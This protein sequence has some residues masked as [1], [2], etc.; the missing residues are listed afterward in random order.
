[1]EVRA[2]DLVSM[3]RRASGLT[4]ASE[5]SALVAL[6]GFAGGG[7]HFFAPRARVRPHSATRSAARRTGFGIVSALSCV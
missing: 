1:M 7:G 2:V 4:I 6:G 3:I 5:E